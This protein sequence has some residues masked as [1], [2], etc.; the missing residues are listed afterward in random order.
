MTQ[1]NGP[2][3]RAGR[4]GPEHFEPTTRVARDAVAIAPDA[5]LLPKD[6]VELDRW[7]LWRSEDGRKVP[8]DVRGCR[9]DVT[10]QHSWSPFEAAA[11]TLSRSPE[12]Y[13]GL[14]FAF[15]AAD[16]LAGIDLDDCI[17]GGAVKA[18]ARGV[19]ERFSDTYMEVS[20]SGRGLK[21][22][23]RGA[24]PTN[25]GGVPVGDGSIEVYTNARYFTVTSCRFRGAPLELEDHSGDLLALHERLTRPNPQRGHQWPV[26][27][28]AN[29][30]IPHGQQHNTLVSLA[31]TLRA[32]GVCDRAI[33]VCLQVVNTDQCELPGRPEEITRIVSSRY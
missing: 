13:T 24:L 21:I 1:G 32:R 14:G 7:L 16:G 15:V 25:I 20:P 4:L 3:R 18:W 28:L 27:P 19:V 33:E 2:E 6:L 23:A 12:Q 17:A 10:K 29:G 5:S 8:Y 31:G 9:A 22:W 30:R 11:E 26:H